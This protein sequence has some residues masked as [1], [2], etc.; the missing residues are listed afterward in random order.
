MLI[1]GLWIQLLQVEILFK[2]ARPTIQYLT[3]FQLTTG[4]YSSSEISE[5][6]HRKK[7]NMLFPK[8]LG[9]HDQERGGK[10]NKMIS[11]LSFERSSSRSMY[12]YWQCATL[13]GNKQLSLYPHSTVPS[14]CSGTWK[15]WSQNIH[16]FTSCC[17]PITK[18]GF[19]KP[20]CL[21]CPTFV[22][23]DWL[24]LPKI[25]LFLSWLLN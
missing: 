9:F 11:N 12:V 6:T 3:C 2:I 15:N 24:L 4:S 5:K 20:F 23:L 22:W 16:R 8:S 25:S 7:L 14:I 19:W 17:H 1:F 10:H 21:K 13:V 18:T